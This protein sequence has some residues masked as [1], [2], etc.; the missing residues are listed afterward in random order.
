M[1]HQ[2]ISQINKTV[3]VGLSFLDKKADANI[4]SISIKQGSEDVSVYIHKTRQR[5]Y[6]RA[7]YGKEKPLQTYVS[8]I[9][10]PSN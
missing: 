3:P 4:L 10:N 9:A 2:D 5:G 8:Y 1:K 6:I 7:I